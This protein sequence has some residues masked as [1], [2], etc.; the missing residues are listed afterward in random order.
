[1]SLVN[2]TFATIVIDTLQQ[3][4]K[5]KCPRSSGKIMMTDV[6]NLRESVG[7]LVCWSVA[8]AMDNAVDSSSTRYLSYWL[9]VLGNF[10]FI[11][12]DSKNPIIW[13]KI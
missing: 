13:R 7:L 2:E 1:M 6:Q 3:T 5:S 10:S 9:T 11:F 8:T 12:F 4:G